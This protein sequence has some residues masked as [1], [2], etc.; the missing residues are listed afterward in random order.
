M[1]HLIS[2][3]ALAAD[4]GIIVFDCRFALMDRD[5]GR[6]AYAAGHIPRARFADLEQDLSA[7]P[8]RGGGV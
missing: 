2:P 4:P 8:G 7:A 5:A 3:Q 6:R 1:Q